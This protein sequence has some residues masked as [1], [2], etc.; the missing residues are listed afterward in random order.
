MATPHILT[1]YKQNN[2]DKKDATKV[3]S[4]ALTPFKFFDK[5]RI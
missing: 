5:T 3:K 2:N 1:S 4:K